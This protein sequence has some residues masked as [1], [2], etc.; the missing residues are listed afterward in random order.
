M[1]QHTSVFL[2]CVGWYVREQLIYQL[3]LMFFLIEMIHFRSRF[4]SV[5]C[6]ET[7]WL[8]CIFVCFFFPPQHDWLVSW[9]GWHCECV[10]DISPA[11]WLSSCLFWGQQASL[12]AS[13]VLQMEEGEG[14]VGPEYDP[15]KAQRR[16]GEDNW[17]LLAAYSPP[18]ASGPHTCSPR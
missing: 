12:S 9:S 11:V 8:M 1:N 6:H 18:T 5:K 14:S 3:V 16:P 10:S 15:V 2:S 13:C 17:H 7:K 4:P